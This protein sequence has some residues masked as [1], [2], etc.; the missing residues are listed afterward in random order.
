MQYAVLRS[1][2]LGRFTGLTE[3]Y[4]SVR[5]CAL[6][7][8]VTHA[9]EA[10]HLGQQYPAAKRGIGRVKWRQE[11]F[12]SLSSGFHLRSSLGNGSSPASGVLLTRPIL[13]PSGLD[14]ADAA[15]VEVEI[16]LNVETSVSGQVVVELLSAE[17]GELLP[18]FRSLPIVGND[19]R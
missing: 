5:V 10:Y 8:V 11:G 19:I 16:A 17:T 7:V 6:L 2:F 13:L 15:E 18:G 4:A 3:L 12:V 9:F 1:C 14:M